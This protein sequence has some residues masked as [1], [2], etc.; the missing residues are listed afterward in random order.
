MR[1]GLGTDGYITDMF[2]VMR[3]AFLIHKGYLQDASVMPAETVLEMATIG[4]AQALGLADQIGSLEVGKKADLIILDPKLPTPLT[5]E[6]AA[7]QLVTFGKANFVQH[8]IVD[9]VQIADNGKVTTT[10]EEVAR[11]RSQN[12]AES[13]W[14]QL[15]KE[16]P[17]RA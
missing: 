12:M 5:I 7:A 9:G 16:A 14:N 15:P 8:V 10:D 17:R 11:L 6:N 4:G 1:V 2:E 3:A 13:L